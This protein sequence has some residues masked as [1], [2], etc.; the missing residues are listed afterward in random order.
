MIRLLIASVVALLSAVPV[1][2][3]Q[4]CGGFYAIAHMANSPSVLDEAV[5]LGANAVEV[6]LAVRPNGDLE[7]FYHGSPCSCTD[8]PD[9]RLCQVNTCETASSIDDM[10]RHI[11]TEQTRIALVIIDVKAGGIKNNEGTRAHVGNKVGAEVVRSLYARGYDGDVIV[12][13]PSLA[14]SSV[15][16]AVWRN[17]KGHAP[18]LSSR[19][20]FS[21]DEEED[22][23]GAVIDTIAS[24]AA[25]NIAYGTGATGAGRGYREAFKVAQSKGVAF[26]YLWTVDDPKI[27]DSYISL[28]VAGILT[29]HPARAADRAVN[30]HSKRMAKRGDL[31]VCP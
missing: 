1:A 2:L 15:L 18:H 12:S 25:G 7:R 26:T 9:A 6:D 11:A 17:V 5:R 21:I 22:N 13:V 3:A 27:I 14:H 16:K 4:Q 19:V 23:A 20:R 8:T 24:F 30:Q 29:D 28:G 10:L 31:L